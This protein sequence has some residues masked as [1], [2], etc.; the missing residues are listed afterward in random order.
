MRRDYPPGLLDS[1]GDDAPVTEHVNA[2]REPAASA[3][4]RCRY[5][6]DEATGTTPAACCGSPAI[7]VHH[8]ERLDRECVPHQ[9]KRPRDESILWCRTCDEHTPRD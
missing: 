3:R 8:C 6:S 1:L 2:P 5:L 7:N 9:L 4:R